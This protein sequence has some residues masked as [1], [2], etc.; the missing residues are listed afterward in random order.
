MTIFFGKFQFNNWIKVKKKRDGHINSKIELL[1]HIS[2]PAP[3]NMTEAID[4]YIKT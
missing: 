4:N 1:Y 2:F 3:D